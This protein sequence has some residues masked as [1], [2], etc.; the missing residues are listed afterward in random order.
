M[1][2][3]N[4][5]LL[6]LALLHLTF[7]VPLACIRVAALFATAAGAPAEV[8]LA[9]TGGSFVCYLFSAPVH[10]ANFVVRCMRVPG[11]ARAVGH[12]VLTAMCP[13]LRVFRDRSNGGSLTHS[14]G[15]MI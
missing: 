13:W 1:K 9:L 12:I 2:Q 14:S 11:F 15:F 7:Y 6:L 8:S 10:L 4:V 5:T 3:A